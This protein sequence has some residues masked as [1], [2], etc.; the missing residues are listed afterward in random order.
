LTGFN[1]NN[2]SIVGNSA[3]IVNNLAGSAVNATCNWWGSTSSGIIAALV[4]GN[5]NYNP[6]W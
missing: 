4:S 6:G 1:V 2:N 5:V 3:G